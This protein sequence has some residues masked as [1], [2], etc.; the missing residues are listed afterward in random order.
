ME[1][2]ELVAALASRI[3]LWVEHD[4]VHDSGAVTDYRGIVIGDA[5]TRATRLR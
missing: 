1:A 3:D 4:H 2:Y 5:I